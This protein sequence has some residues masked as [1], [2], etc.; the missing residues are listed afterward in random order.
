MESSKLAAYVASRICHDV[1]SPL[2]SLMTAQ[3]LLFTM[4]PDMRAMG[5]KE[6]KEGIAK[7]QAKLE[8]LRFA[9]GSQSLND[10]LANL[11]EARERSY[12]LVSTNHK[13]ELE[14]APEAVTISNLQMRLLMNMM[15]IMIEPAT[16]GVCRV[17][18]KEEGG[19]M[20]L[21]VEAVGRYAEF[22]SGVQDG[23][24]GREPEGGWGGGAIQPYFTRQLAEELG[25]TLDA[26]RD[27]GRSA[28][29]LIAR[30][31]I[32]AG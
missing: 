11:N 30:G 19:E 31:P 3:D 20:V 2:Q 23:L 9:I 5:E 18:A 15:L 6:F 32:A 24:V 26:K 13:C 27:E 25:F 28:L 10:G 1:A 4:G 14:W 7:L 16:R 17:L 12:K 29:A 22:K 8:F 21:T